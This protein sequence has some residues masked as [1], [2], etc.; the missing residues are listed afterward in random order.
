MGAILAVASAS[1]QTFTN[2]TSLLPE[3][4]N[5]GGCVGVTDMNNDGYDDIIVLH[6]S[7]HL[8]IFY[9]TPQ[10]FNL[11]PYGTISSNNQWGMAIG[12]INRDGHRDVI[13]GGAYDGV[14]L[15]QITEQGS[16]TTF[17]L[18]NGNMFMQACNVVDIDND[19]HLDYFA[20]HDDALSRM[21]KNDGAGNLI[22]A[23]DLI[24]LT[25]YDF[26]NFPNTDHSG[27]YGSVWSDIDN[28]GN[29][30]LI[31]AKCRQGVSNPEDPRRINQAW[32]NDGNGNWSEEAIDRGI[33]VFQ[34]SWT[35]DFADVNNDG[36]LDC[37]L[38]N[39]TSTLRL[40]LNDGTGHFTDITTSAGLA[41]SGFFLQAKMV[42]FDNDGFVDIIYSGGV[43][44]YYRNNGDNTFTHVPSTFPYSDTMHSFGIGD[45]NRDGFLD[46]YAS[47]GNG[48]V[49]PDANNPDILWLNNGNEN[50]WVVFDLEGVTS[51]IDAIG[52]KVLIYGDW[53]VQ[54]REVRSGESYGIVNTFHMHFGIGQSTSIDQVVVQWPSGLVTTIEN[55]AINTFHSIIEALCFVDDVEIVAQ[56]STTICQ[57]ESLVITAPEGFGYAWSEGS[58]TQEITV[59]QSGN[60]SVLV[61]NAEGCAGFS[62]TIEVE[63]ITIDQPTISA[64]HELIFCQGESITLT[65]SEGLAYAWSNAAED[66]SIVVTQSGL[67]TVQVQGV[68]GAPLTSEAIEV[69]VLEAQEPA[70]SPVVQVTPGVDTGLYATGSYVEWFAAEF[71]NT[72]IATGNELIVNIDEPTS[73]WLQNT[74]PHGGLVGEG[75]KMN[76]TTEGGQY[77]TNSSFW[78]V[79]DAYEDFILESVKVFAGTS[80]NRT[81]ALI[82]QSG[83]I[84]QSLVV[85]IPLGE[86]VVELNFFVPAGSGYG[87]RTVGNNPQLWRDGLPAEFNYPY[88][89][90][91][92][93]AITGTSITG[94][95]E[96]NFYYF[97]YDW[98]V[99][100]PTTECVSMR[101]ELLVEPL[102]EPNCL[103]DFDGDGLVSTSDLLIFL[104]NF[105]CLENCVTDLDGDGAVTTSDLLV[106]LSVFGTNCD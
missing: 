70:I 60:Y 13:S 104:A 37:L 90:G 94:L 72:P 35:V 6:N 73:F 64:S 53:G 22:P 26:S 51:N 21:W 5:S 91:E 81:I 106:F 15:V 86:E 61:T 98:K 9:Q 54:V 84:I 58:S 89:I 44:R 50:N 55:P 71:D 79:F 2:S 47:Y 102:A 48:Y 46:V 82:D 88:A 74:T 11:V 33:A 101:I 40:L 45:L 8:H 87:L 69:V 1:A 27:N 10:G 7:R 32:M 14:R 77:H 105:G 56:G 34:Q 76:I 52:A 78:Q 16:A 41:V 96:F 83:T 12:D 99:R 59:S 24:D 39:H 28:D 20:C 68:C 31:I 85:N 36:F 17:T 42:D 49:S 65:A 23:N 38:T 67:Y 63:V 100:T 93:G 57:G 95:N 75:G 103:G 4:F 62:N 30:D 80:A 66:Q 25:D 18:P 19:G 3:I 43:H 29:L 92:L 97:F